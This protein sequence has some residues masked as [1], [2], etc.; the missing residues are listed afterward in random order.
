ME[1]STVIGQGTQETNSNRAIGDTIAMQLASIAYCSN[2]KSIDATL[3]KYLPEWTAVWTPKEE[4][5]GNY[6]FIA[7]NNVQYVV[8][9]RGSVAIKLNYDAWENWIKEDLNIFSQ[10]DW[11]YPSSS[12]NPKISAGSSIGLHHLNELVNDDEQTMLQ[13][14]ME[15][16]IPNGSLLC[17]TG[18][19]LGANL[20]TVYA[21]WLKYQ[22]ESKGGTIPPLFSVLTFA[23][24]TSWNKAFA[25]QFDAAFT[26]SWRYY[27]V[28]DMVPYSACDIAGLG[29][30]YP[31]PAPQAENV[32]FLAGF[33][34]LK[35]AFDYYASLV[36]KSETNHN[37]YYH[38]VNE[39]RG[40]VP[41]NK[42]QKI[43]DVGGDSD[44]DKWFLQVGAQHSHDHY[45]QWL[46]ASSLECQHS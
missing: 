37:S 38:H 21:P 3:E 34:N 39:S 31:S 12:S 45:L 6:A 5:G 11:N 36:E 42:E 13:Y 29:N 1:N 43:F 40:A 23:A 15:N 7:Y 27:N 25:D 26:N 2:K 10:V 16:A 20:A 44:L 19:S 33:L 8:A 41:L 14:L 24:P 4:K 35:E 32:K 9:I 17:V 28:I 46:G 22:I 18:H 30:L